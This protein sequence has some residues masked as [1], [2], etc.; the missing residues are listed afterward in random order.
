MISN[1]KTAR[2]VGTLFLTGFFTSMIDSTGFIGPII[3]APD[4]LI[5]VYPNKTQVIT[6]MLLELI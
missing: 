3:N 4:Y 5:N 2:I 6:G 1:K